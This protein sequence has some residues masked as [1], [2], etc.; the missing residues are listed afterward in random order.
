LFCA[1]IVSPAANMPTAVAVSATGASHP[2]RD[3]KR[4][5][6]SSSAGFATP[7]ALAQGGLAAP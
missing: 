2:I 5:I 7:Q 6:C 4:V 3:R 1:T